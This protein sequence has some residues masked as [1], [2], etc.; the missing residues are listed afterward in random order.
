M[1]STVTCTVEGGLAQVRLERPDK[2]NALT[3]DTLEAL[4]A[5]AR[6][7]R[8]DRTLRGVVLAGSGDSF[9]AGLDFAAVLSEPPRV[10]RAFLPR[11]WRGTNLFQEACWAWRRLPVP[12]VA[13][14]HGHCYGGGLQIALA[15]DLR[16]TT[17]DARWSVLEARWGLVPDMSGIQALAQQVRMDVAKRLTMTGEVVSGARAVE[18]GLASEVHDEPVAAATALLEQVATRSPDSVA[19]TKRLF[20]RT[21][22]AGAR[23]TFARER[24]EQAV[25]LARANTRAAREA[26]LRGATPTFGPRAR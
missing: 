10:A 2:L 1:P 13:A 12:V 17:P 24:V 25:L 9:C 8:G 4:V 26:A 7:L 20:E 15:A 21:W 23:R 22:S 5:T 11:P 14:V 3:L 18:L 16:M 6:S 19:A